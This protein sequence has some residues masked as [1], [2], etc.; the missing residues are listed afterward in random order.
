MK[1]MVT[2]KRCHDFIKMYLCG[3]LSLMS[4]SVCVCVFLLPSSLK[5]SS[6]TVWVSMW[7]ISLTSPNAWLPTIDGFITNT[8]LTTLDRYRREK[9]HSVELIHSVHIQ[10]N[11]NSLP[12]C[13]G[14]LFSYNMNKGHIT[15]SK[16]HIGYYKRSASKSNEGRY[17]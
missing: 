3:P 1:E 4:F 2:H 17:R 9:M 5:E 6:T 8:T 14:Q 16:A 11:N 7:R 13:I 12:H 15:N 10:N